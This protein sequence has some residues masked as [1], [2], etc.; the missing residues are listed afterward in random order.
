MDFRKIVKVNAIELKLESNGKGA[1][2]TEEGGTRLAEMTIGISGNNLTVYHTEVSEQLRR[3]GVASQLLLAMVTYS[4]T[5]DL[6][7]IALCPYVSAVPG[8]L[9]SELACVVS[10][11]RQ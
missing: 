11:A 9:E 10:R 6:K 7:V 2:V 8:Y 4:R 3:A 5:H 1:F